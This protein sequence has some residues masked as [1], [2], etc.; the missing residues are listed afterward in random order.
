MSVRATAVRVLG[1]VLGL[2]PLGLL[3]LYLAPPS[4]RHTPSR[5]LGQPH[6][7]NWYSPVYDAVDADAI[8]VGAVP[9]RATTVRAVY[10]G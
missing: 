3:L 10:Y 5:H 9:I 4:I 2:E 6:Q 1:L 8:R 7:R